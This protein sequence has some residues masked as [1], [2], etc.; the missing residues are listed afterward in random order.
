MKNDHLL[1]KI[2]FALFVLSI[3][4]RVLS[5]I[6]YGGISQ[7]LSDMQLL[8]IP[9]LLAWSMGFFISEGKKRRK[10]KES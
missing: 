8:F 1:Q 5:K 9:A 6:L 3:V 4:C 2:G 10:K 7:I